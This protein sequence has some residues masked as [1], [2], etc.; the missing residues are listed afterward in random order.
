MNRDIK[1][2]L[3]L[4][5][6]LFLFAMGGWLAIVD[7]LDYKVGID[8][9]DWAETS[10]KIL[11]HQITLNHPEGNEV[12]YTIVVAYLYHVK[13]EEFRGTRMAF[14]NQF[15]V[16][17]QDSHTLPEKYMPNKEVVVF[18][19]PKKPA[20]STL[21]KG[22]KFNSYLEKLIR[23]IALLAIPVG[24]FICYVSGRSKSQMENRNAVLPLSDNQ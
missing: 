16:K 22:V 8:S 12:S 15:E 3:F 19:D 11:E 9:R 10:G 21:E 20:D 1:S 17:N 24:I 4:T 14:P 6:G 18:Y 7:A 23:D 5:V 13:N 2:L